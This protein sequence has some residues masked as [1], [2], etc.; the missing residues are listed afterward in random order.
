MRQ[1]ISYSGDNKLMADVKPPE[2]NKSWNLL[3]CNGFERWFYKWHECFNMISWHT[4]AA[5]LPLKALCWEVK[6]I[7]STF[8]VLSIHIKS[9]FV[10]VCVVIQQVHLLSDTNLLP[11]AWSFQW[12]FSG[13]MQHTDCCRSSG[14]SV[15]S[16]KPKS[17]CVDAMTVTV[18]FLI[19][20][21]G[22]S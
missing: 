14:R 8:T 21:D 11:F 3:V 12:L 13:I 6:S 22:Y 17:I 4:I 9:W 18:P 19:L 2:R 5:I 15:L 20:A 7:W 16:V 1:A 10:S